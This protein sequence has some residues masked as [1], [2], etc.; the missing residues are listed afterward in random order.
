MNKPTKLPSIPECRAYL[1]ACGHYMGYGVD[2]SGPNKGRYL[3]MLHYTGLRHL[4]RTMHLYP[5]TLRRMIQRE[6][7]NSTDYNKFIVKSNSKKEANRGKRN[8]TDTAGRP[9]KDDLDVLAPNHGLVD[10]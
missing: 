8:E 3:L 6:R 4:V 7:K 2:T 1:K 10:G 9:V 5:M